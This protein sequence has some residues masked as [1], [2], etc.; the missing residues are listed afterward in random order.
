M[1]LVGSY[2]VTERTHYREKCVEQPLV[3]AE[4]CCASHSLTQAFSQGNT[5]G[6]VKRSEVY[7]S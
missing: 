2:P 4:V 5:E 3:G 1:A 7:V 6:T